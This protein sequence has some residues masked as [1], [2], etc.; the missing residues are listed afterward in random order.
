MAEFKSLDPGYAERIRASFSRQGFM[1]TLGAE[2]SDIKPG[3][4]EITV[5]YDPALTQQHGYFHGGLIGTIADN[6]AGYASGSLMGPEDSL[7]TVEYKL[8]FMSPA[9]GERLISRGQ[10]VRPGRTI[11][12]SK[13]DVFAFKDGREYRCA[14]LLGTFMKLPDTPDNPHEKSG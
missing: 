12:V 6:A 14:T 9:N 13:A 11:T 8:N 3:F 5:P 1:I 7:L 4:A 2:L 10:V